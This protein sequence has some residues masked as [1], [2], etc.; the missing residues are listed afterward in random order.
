MPSWLILNHSLACA[1]LSR[2]FSSR[3]VCEP[4]SRLGQQ[5]WR[6]QQEGSLRETAAAYKCQIYPGFLAATMEHACSRSTINPLDL[7]PFIERSD[8]SKPCFLRLL[9]ENVICAC[10]AR[11]TKTQVF[12]RRLR[13]PFFVPLSNSG[14]P[15]SFSPEQEEP[16]AKRRWGRLHM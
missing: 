4:F 9:F 5:Q 11:T 2:L 12:R 14:F 1:F 6:R 10:Y 16:R 7:L 13:L 15:V 3:T 8:M